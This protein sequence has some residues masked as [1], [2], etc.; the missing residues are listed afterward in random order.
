MRLLC[1]CNTITLYNILRWTFIRYFSFVVPGQKTLATK[2]AL[3]MRKKSI[4]KCWTLRSVFKAKYLT[5][6]SCQMINDNANRPPQAIIQWQA[7][8][9]V[10]IYGLPK[11]Y[12]TTTTLIASVQRG[13]NVLQRKQ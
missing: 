10:K 11:N 6:K 1:I 13:C 7:F 4:S 2:H 12:M 5:Q 3:T 9:F 8:S